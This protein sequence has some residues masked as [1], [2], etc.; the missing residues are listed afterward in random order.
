MIVDLAA[1]TGG[2]CEL[3]SPGE[4]VER[5]GVTIMGPLNLAS[6]MPTHASCFT[7]ATCPPCSRTSRW[8][9]ELTLD[10]DDEITAGACVTRKPEL[11][12]GAGGRSGMSHYATLELTVLALAIFLGIEVI[13]S[14]PDDAAHA[15]HVGDEAIHGIVIGAMLVAGQPHADGVTQA[16]GFVAMILAAANVVG[17]W[18]V[19]DRMLQMFKNWSRRPSAARRTRTV[20]G[21]PHHLEPPL[22]VTIICF[23]LALR[24]L[25]SPKHARLGNRIGAVGMAVA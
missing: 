16:I 24:F 9:A 7:H 8:A 18:V 2:N 1:E 12:S 22:P 10:W 19:T 4:T 6:S 17:G 25:S 3:T 14:C 11:P 20:S 5:D 15:A 21:E 23:V 13:S